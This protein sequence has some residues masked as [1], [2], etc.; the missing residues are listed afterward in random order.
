[1][2]D[3]TPTARENEYFD[4]HLTGLGYLNRFRSV[5]VRKGTSFDILA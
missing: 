3:S 1:M 5:P 4:L 2:N